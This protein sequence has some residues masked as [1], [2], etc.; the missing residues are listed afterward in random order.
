M[1]RKKST[2][3]KIECAKYMPPLYHTVPDDEF[4]IKK[5]QVV[6]W[7]IKSPAI[8]NYLWDHIKQSGLVEYNSKTGKWQGVDYDD[9]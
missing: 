5:S 3:K 6:N 4:N 7:L 2:S 9:N 8:L 1:G